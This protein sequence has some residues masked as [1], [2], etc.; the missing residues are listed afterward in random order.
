MTDRPSGPSRN[1]SDEELGRSPAEDSRRR[2]RVDGAGRS[3]S[4]TT[5]E[6]RSAPPTGQAPPGTEPPTAPDQPPG[7][8]PL[9]QPTS[10][11]SE[12]IVN[13]LP[14]RE[15]ES[16][17]P[18][19]PHVRLRL[20]LPNRTI[21]RVLLALGALWFV[22]QVWTILL[23]A[24]VG[25]LLAM[26]V[27]PLVGRLERRGFSYR[28][29]LA[30][31][32]AGFLA[33]MA[34]LLGVV[35]PQGAAQINDLWDNLP[36]YMEEAF[37]FLEPYQPDLYDQIVEWSEDVQAGGLSESIDVEG[38][39]RAGQTVAIGLG[40]TV[41][42]IAIAVYVLVDRE[43]RFLNW[44]TRD[45]SPRNRAKVR[46][47]LPAVTDVVSGYVLGQGLISL[48]FAVFA[49]VVLTVL[50]VPSALVL[51]LIAFVA[52]AIPLI[53]IIVATVPATA[54]G[55]TQGWM[56]GAIVLASFLLYQQF[57]NYVLAPRVFGRTLKLSPLAILVAVL[58]GG[59]L[60]GILGV[61]LALPLAASIPVLE[62]IWLHDEAEPTPEEEAVAAARPV[63]GEE[64]FGT[65][66]T[67]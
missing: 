61:V 57:E 42:V 24:F 19:P 25:V 34:L 1:K 3:P 11:E 2:A 67:E 10:P 7:T 21:L 58:I 63:F 36:T 5:A 17:P 51:A 64:T 40:N 14:E 49:F 31:V 60:L 43:F 62:R 46:R 8:T 53:G 28:A 18:L 50:G 41:I 4:P 54:L 22:F 45:L 32:L 38:A 16:L 52:D 35:V 6:A 66:V 13:L 23:N 37:S 12:R 65:R 9:A 44:L 33:A 59:Q 20:E 26:A 47:T 39:L 56:V 15:G 30:T 29:A 55:L 48:C 27:R